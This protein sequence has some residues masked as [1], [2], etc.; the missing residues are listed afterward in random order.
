MMEWAT[1]GKVMDIQIN[2]NRHLNTTL[3]SYFC[4]KQKFTNT[5]QLEFTRRNFVKYNLADE[6]LRVYVGMN[7]IIRV[8]NYRTHSK[9]RVSM[10]R[11]KSKTIF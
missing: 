10:K 11:A 9:L 4:T 1:K 2:D 3:Q 8:T 7:Y 6:I 5:F